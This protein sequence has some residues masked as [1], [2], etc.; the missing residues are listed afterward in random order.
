M[1]YQHSK[2]TKVNVLPECL[3][4]HSAIMRGDDRYILHIQIELLIQCK[5]SA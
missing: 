4:T 3:H 2:E 5:T 1:I